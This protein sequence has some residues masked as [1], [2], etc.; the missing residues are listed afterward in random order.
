MNEKPVWPLRPIIRAST[1]GSSIVAGP[2]HSITKVA[3]GP[4]GRS[5]RF[6][7]Y[8]TVAIGASSDGVSRWSRTAL[9]V[10]S[11][12]RACIRTRGRS[13]LTLRTLIVGERLTIA[14]SGSGPDWMLE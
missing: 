11:W 7:T 9:P 5:S 14:G 3:P 1:M 8:S 2:A 13:A 4:A 6:T 10:E 12:N